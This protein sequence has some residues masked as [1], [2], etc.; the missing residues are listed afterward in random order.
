M[1]VWSVKTR[2][3]PSR[4]SRDEEMRRSMAI[5]TTTALNEVNYPPSPSP[6][7][8]ISG[9]ATPEN[10]VNSLALLSL[11]KKVGT[12]CR[13][14]SFERFLRAMQFTLR[15]T[16]RPP[17]YA[18]RLVQ[19]KCLPG[20]RE[21]RRAPSRHRRDARVYGHATTAMPKL[22]TPPPPPLPNRE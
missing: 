3:A 11:H 8:A 2:S 20:W 6:R 22:S 15:A 13:S 9:V 17:H 7:I 12:R 5:R 14:P 21:T 19:A 18:S 16:Q 4:H 1:V 10:K